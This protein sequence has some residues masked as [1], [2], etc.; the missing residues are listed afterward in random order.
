[1]RVWPFIISTLST[2]ILVFLLNTSF[3]PLPA[4]GPFFEPQTGFWQNAEAT[5]A[6]YAL[7]LHFQEL[8]A[9][10]KVY[11]DKR[12]I[13]HVF[14][15]NERDAYFAEG[16]LHARFRLW[17]MDLQ[18]RLA[19]GRLTEVLGRY[20]GSR[21]LLQIVDRSYRRLGMAYSA[22]QALKGM[23]ADP[24]TK[25]ECDAYTEGVNAYMSTLTASSL[26]LEYKL[27]DCTPEPW[28]NLKTALLLKL[29]SLDL[30]GGENDFE[31]T[32]ARNL[33]SA[34]DFELLYPATQDSID[35]IVPVG[36]ELYGKRDTP[37]VRVRMPAH[38]DTNYLMTK[39]GPLPYEF[40][41]PDREN[42]SNNWAVSGS[43]TRSGAPILCNDPHLGLNLP[44]LWYEMQIHT[45]DMNVY[46]VAFPGAPGI[47]IG[48]NDSCAFGFTNAM[49]DVR[50]YF[51][52]QF[53][54]YTRKEY[55]YNG[56]WL[57][58]TFR[59]EDI[60]VRGEPDFMDTVAYTV[61]GPVMY[62]PSYPDPLR[63]GRYYACKWTA[64]D[65]SNELLAFHDLDHA[66]NYSDYLAAI[67]HLHTPGQ[68]C[69]FA[70]RDGDIAIWD[71]GAFPAKWFRQGDF[72]M[73]GIDTT[74]AW[75]GTIPQAENPHMVNPARG[76]V[77]SAN[78][79][80]VDVK[81]Y[82]YYLGGNF[83]PYRG[84]AINRRL[85]NTTNATAEDMMDLQTDNYD[86]FA[87]MARPLFLKYI[88]TSIMEPAG[89]QYYN[90]VKAW[91]LRNNAR[92]RAPSIFHTWW[93]SLKTTIYGDELAQTDL[94][95]MM[96]YDETLLEA[97]LK[98]ST[99]KFVDDIRTP[100]TETLRQMATLA[101]KKI[102]PVVL[103]ADSSGT[104]NW[105]V[106]KDT[107]VE[108]LLRLDALSDLHLPIGGGTYSINA[109]R[110]DHGPSWR[111]VVELS[112]PIKAFGIYPG[113]QSGNPG[114][115]FYDDL[116]MPWA[117]GQ[118]D[119]LW[120][121][122]PGQEADP[123]VLWKMNFSKP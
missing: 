79:V 110:P 40:W 101:W 107:R 93:D 91:N 56:E 77:S 89:L 14:A 13:P 106:F 23:E 9:P 117:K 15:Q 45:P 83:P 113:G 28:T 71:Q 73:P 90:L 18:T 88:D 21:D 43:R 74:Y 120:V 3:R 85:E 115:P 39:G 29:M 103:Q 54:D 50:D 114:S 97:L 61:W 104:L 5:T 44:S 53:K 66:A 122:T 36:T 57:P 30:A 63:S 32:N 7:D 76:F 121:M 69:V 99:Y 1:M 111:M 42:G 16:Y 49:R 4:L 46:G 62:E 17:Q 27:L 60:K 119:T 95:I 123:R 105:S 67:Q 22:E 70:S 8:S 51:E 116:V 118:Y 65:E 6:D 64:Q 35:P 109:A 72:V 84:M 24:V 94:P 112:S 100:Q 2:G 12:L 55:R 34:S 82:P 98:D 33:F 48:F 59:V 38:V 80:P 41:K 47:I 52:V 68:N 11:L 78:Q 20:S 26:P 96:P 25:A 81:T 102:Y 92:E 10:V 19:A 37:G 86:V 87:E 108:H 75:Q 58:T 31:L